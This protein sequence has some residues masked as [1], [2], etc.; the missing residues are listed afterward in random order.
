MRCT[1]SA[2]PRSNSRGSMVAAVGPEPLDHLVLGRV[3]Q[4]PRRRA[5][6]A[7]QGPGPVRRHLAPGAVPTA[8]DL[9][10]RHELV[11]EHVD[12]AARRPGGAAGGVEPDVRA[13]RHVGQPRRR[14][15]RIHDPRRDRRRHGDD[16][17][18]EALGGPEPA[19][20]PPRRR[21]T[22]LRT[23]ST[24]TPVRTPSRSPSTRHG[25]SMPPSTWK[26]VP[27]AS[28]R[29]HERSSAALISSSL[30]KNGPSISGR[31][32][33]SVAAAAGRRQLV[34]SAARGRGARR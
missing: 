22:T 32:I 29:S 23:S 11:R 7:D 18:V 4:R 13:V 33:R 25:E 3:E 1:T 8:A 28:T 5:R 19:V 12:A 16:R 30:A 26:N 20:T 27:T 14:G 2:E 31:T 15:R 21:P 17:A 34:E 24:R 10:R 9:G 6:G